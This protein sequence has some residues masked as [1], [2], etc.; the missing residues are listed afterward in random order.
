MEERRPSRGNSACRRNELDRL[1]RWSLCSVMMMVEVV[2]VVGP[3]EAV[4]DECKRYE[5]QW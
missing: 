4:V 3:T 5:T 2:V 1:F